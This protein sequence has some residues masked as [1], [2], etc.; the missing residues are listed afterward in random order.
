[1]K[2]LFLSVT[3]GQGHN[4]TAKAIMTYM[5][6]QG[7]ECVL[8]DTFDYINP[9]L[10]ESIARG[11]LISTKFTPVVYGRLYRLAEKME[12]NNV[13]MSV[14]NLTNYVLA[15]K[16]T[17]YIKEFDPDVI[18]TTHI[19][20]AQIL[21]HIKSK[22]LRALTVGIVTDFTIH[23]FWQETELDYYVTAS[24]LLN[25]QAQK[26]GIPSNKIKPFGIPI[27]TKFCQEAPTN[28]ARAAL[29]IE[30]KDT[31][32]VM[33]GSMGYGNVTRI[34][35]QLDNLEQDFQILSVC[36][37]NKGLKRKID[38]LKPKKKIVNFGFVDNVD[39][40]MDAS[41]C[42]VTKPGGLTVSE[43]LAKGLP[44]VLMRPIPGQEERNVEF[45]LN[46]GLAVRITKTYPIDEA[47]FQLLL[48]P[49][50]TQAMVDRIHHI[51]KPYATR[52]LCSFIDSIQ[53]SI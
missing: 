14:T 50:S 41:N 13:Q 22:G 25:R 12:H 46:N 21:S 17:N 15:K 44:M 43:S 38:A 23:P 36:G 28:E 31:I 9:M 30:D 49:E 34:I 52:D 6:G 42:I 40:M 29:G 16:L 4:Q 37:S 45:L 32:F 1:M 47:I 33:S 51:A 27:Q 3:A 39:V 2:V 26:K 10:S 5:Q 53:S 8:L 48:D 18:I 11:Y 19:F 20:A 24:E 35:K 7:N